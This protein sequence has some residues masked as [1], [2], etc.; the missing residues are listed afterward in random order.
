MNKKFFITLMLSGLFSLALSLT[1]LAAA[2]MEKPMHGKPA[3]MQKMG[4]PM[5]GKPAPMRHMEKPMHAKPA[6]MHNKDGMKQMPGENRGMPGG[7]ERGGME[8]RHMDKKPMPEQRRERHD[9]SGNR[10]GI[11]GGIEDDRMD[12][13]NADWQRNRE[14]ER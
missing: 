1:A 7:M 3:P 8:N 13:G 10:K 5:H 9:L 14:L 11:H 2:P 6:P 4:K 12:R